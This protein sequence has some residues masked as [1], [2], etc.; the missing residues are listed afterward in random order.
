LIADI[1]PTC[2]VAGVAQ[3]AGMEAFSIFE[4]TPVGLV[5]F[6]NGLAVLLGAGMGFIPRT[7]AG[8]TPTTGTDPPT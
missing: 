7:A 8:S 3:D 4:I 1:K 2:C 5:T 6:R